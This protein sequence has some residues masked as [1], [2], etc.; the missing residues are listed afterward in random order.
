[1]KLKRLQKELNALKEQ[2]KDAGVSDEE[3][4]RLESDKSKL[5]DQLTSLMEEK[6]L[7]RVS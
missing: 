1:V 4:Q 5:K 6:E 2:Q 7:Q 3:F